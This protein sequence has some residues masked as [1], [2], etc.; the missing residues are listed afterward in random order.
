MAKKKKRSILYEYLIKSSRSIVIL[1]LLS[2]VISL[3]NLISPELKK[4]F[5]NKALLYKDADLIVIITLGSIVVL[6]VTNLVS[7]IN[8][9]YFN[10]VAMNI[11]KEMKKD[12]V[13]RMIKM[14]LTMFNSN[15]NGYINARL[16][17]VDQ[18]SG[19]FSTTVFETIIS[20]FTMIG[21]LIYIYKT[22]IVILGITLL[23]MPVMFFI[24]KQNGKKLSGIS[25]KIYES[26]AKLS[27]NLMENIQGISELK[28][29]N[30]EKSIIKSVN[31]DIN[32]IF[33]KQV[34][35]SA[36]FVSGTTKIQFVSALVKALV[37]MF[38]GFRIVSGHLTI[39]DYVSLI[40]YISISFSP[41]VMI[42]NY[43]LMIRPS[44]V[45]LRRIE[46][47]FSNSTQKE[48]VGKVNLT[49]V[50]SI[51]FRDLSFGYKEDEMIFENV[52][53]DIEENEKVLIKGKNGT[54][55]STLVKII[56]GLV[57]AN[58][59]KVLYNC[60]DM[61]KYNSESIRNN[62]GLISQTSVLFS[63]TIKDNVMLIEIKE[64]LWNSIISNPI[65]SGV[66]WEHGIVIEDGKNLSS[67]QRQKILFARL[68]VREPNVVIIDEGIT[69]LD[70]ESQQ[71]VKKCV[72][73]LFHNKICIII[74]HSDLF[75]DVVDKTV[76][77]ENRTAKTFLMKS[78][79]TG[80]TGGQV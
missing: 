3:L 8:K 27:G 20:L 71:F 47:F 33:D 36:I 37:S 69:N 11:Q 17:E 30:S 55:K 65:F 41:A 58:K 39:G 74:T 43:D 26:E 15:Q 45:A 4:I 61:E 18:I 73:E 72:S 54:G 19:L 10:Y 48:E 70:S 50:K 25:S 64:E 40:E 23:C 5:I 49:F 12:L 6:I 80:L 32:S 2:V 42:G 44:V 34:K 66:D 35:R 53:F 62:I 9:Y 78:E 60:L 31:K 24:T 56:S 29:L 68:L 22:D 13:S 63:G 76:L 1:F 28:Q 16:K 14:S 52:T 7:L 79:Q 46:E 75:D 38:I 51:G 59:G 57:L 77:F 67:G 21:A